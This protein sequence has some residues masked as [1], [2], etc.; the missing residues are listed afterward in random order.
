[1]EN[2]EKDYR[3]IIIIVLLVFCIVFFEI[4]VI[5]ELTKK[6]FTEA[7]TPS[8][9]TNYNWYEEESEIASTETD[10]L[11]TQTD[12]AGQQP[13]DPNKNTESANAPIDA[14]ADDEPDPDSYARREWF[15]LEGIP[16]DILPKLNTVQIMNNMQDMLYAQAYADYTTATYSEHE[17]NESYIDI[18]FTVDTKPNEVTAQVLYY[19]ETDTAI[20]RLYD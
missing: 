4:V 19:G 16:E 10:N 9:E 2:K 20:I 11:E 3:K 8:T 14:T 15:K 5:Y 6:G 7:E 12:Q 13:A 1:M 18:W 17:E